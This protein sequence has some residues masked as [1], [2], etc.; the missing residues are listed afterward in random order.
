M[1]FTPLRLPPGA[2]LRRTLEQHAVDHADGPA[3]FVVAG[4]GSLDG[5]VLRLA[6]AEQETRW[7][8][9]FEILSLSGSLSP[10]GAHLHMS[11]ADAQGRVWGGHVAY[12][13]VVRTTVELVVA[14]MVGW[15]LGREV[16]SGTGYLE[17]TIRAENVGRQS[18]GQ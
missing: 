17:V 10:Q 6:A 18:S 9:P 3:L 4:I 8:G 16:D 1:S 7:T 11:A 15:R 12:G 13:N 2:D 5:A 14:E